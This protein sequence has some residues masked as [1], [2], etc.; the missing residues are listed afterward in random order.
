MENQAKPTLNLPA[1][2]GFVAG[3][4]AVLDLNEFVTT[5]VYQKSEL[6]WSWDLN[7]NT[8]ITFIKSEKAS[9]S[10]ASSA[11]TGIVL[12]S[13]PDDWIGWERVEF[14]VS[15]PMGGAAKDTLIVFSVPD[16]GSPLAGGLNPFSIKAGQCKTISLEEYYFDA[17]TQSNN[18]AWTVSG[19]DSITVSIDP[20]THMATI[21][22][23]SETWEGEE[24]LSFLVTDNDDNS[25]SMGVTVTVTDAVILKIFSTMIFR[26]PMQ[27]DYMG[28]YI[29][30]KKELNGL[31]TVDIKMDSDSTPVTIKTMSTQYYYGQYLLPLDKSLGVKGVADVIVSGTLSTGKTVRDTSKFAYGKVDT[32]GAK[33]ALGAV[34]LDL[35]SGALSRPVF[36]TMIPGQEITDGSDG[37][38]PKEV[39]LSGLPYSI[40]PSSLSPVRPIRVSF[41][42]SPQSRGAGIYRLYNGSWC[43]IGSGRTQNSVQAEVLVGG[44][45]MVGFDNTPP[46]MKLLDSVGETIIIAAVDYGS[47]IDSGTIHVRNDDR[48]LSFD[49]V[50]ER[51]VIIVDRNLMA[52][53]ASQSLEVTVLDKSGNR[54]VAT[55]TADVVLP[56]R[57]TLEQN[58][59][60][61]FNPIRQINFENTSESMIILEV[62]DILGRK[63][64]VLAHDRF[65]S[66]SHMVIWDARDTNDRTVSSGTYIYRIKSDTQLLSR[67]MLLLR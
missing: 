28:F 23:L 65:P 26:N 32:G 63:V 66:G 17:D 54:N 6:T 55:F 39:M 34:T 61:P 24:N 19:N 15:N 57:T 13:G 36:I 59:P 51:G 1:K 37:K 45:F 44:T 3:G 4:N 48:E 38:T 58:R 12:L 22:T 14:T 11:Q 33:L 56:D 7:I 31:P 64:R 41:P 62:Y 25:S 27:E 10:S 29:T 30:S 53:I 49:Y 8:T 16:D 35:P 52:E 9:K 42:M 2:V 18:I 21:Y 47:G 60:N 50:P 40:G 5:L 43:F 20:T 67:K 46:G